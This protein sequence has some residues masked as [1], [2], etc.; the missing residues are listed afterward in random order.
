MVKANRNYI[1]LFLYGLWVAS[2]VWLLSGCQAGSGVSS[3]EQQARLDSLVEN[4]EFLIHADFAVPLA[5]QAYLSAANLGYA[6]ARG[7]SPARVNLTGE[8][9]FLSLKKDS[10]RTDLPYF[11]TRDNVTNYGRRGGGIKLETEIEDF[12]QRKTER[13]Y[14]M[15]FFAREEFERFRFILTVYPN[16]ET[17]LSVFSPQR[18][19]IRYTGKIQPNQEGG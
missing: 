1:F 11:G 18:D 2:I 9:Y 10:V 3:P 12:S 17:Q 16:L 5:T 14:E 19:I 6:Q 8:G 15:E 4:R 13:G 7:S